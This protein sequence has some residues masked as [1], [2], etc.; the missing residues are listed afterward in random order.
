MPRIYRPTLSKVLFL[1]TVNAIKTVNASSKNTSFSWNIP[2]INIYELGQVKVGSIASTL[3]T[4]DNKIYTFRLNNIAVN[5][6]SSYSSD[7]GQPILI[8]SLLNNVST[9]N[10]NNNVGIY[11]MPQS[12][13]NITISVSDD[14]TV[15][16][17]GMAT[18]I[19]F[20]I[21]L[22]IDDL[23]IVMNDIGEPYTDAIQEIKNRVRK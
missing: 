21:S 3:T 10:I 15:R 7:G 2:E 18:T 12:I 13:N 22:I 9:G 16:E 11:L 19:N 5:S 4:A 1:N 20:V 8:S 23:Q 14:L 17:N 6:S